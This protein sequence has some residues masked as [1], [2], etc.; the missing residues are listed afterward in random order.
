MD[1]AIELKKFKCINCSY[2]TNRK[3]NYMYHIN[4]KNPCKS[5]VKKPSGN[6]D[7][8]NKID[9][10]EFE[11][12]NESVYGDDC[13]F[14]DDSLCDNDEEEYIIQY[15]NN[16][17][18]KNK[19]CD[20]CDKT[21]SSLQS[22][23][24]HMKICNGVNSLQCTI[25]KKIFSSRNGKHL[26]MKYVTCEP[27]QNVQQINHYTTNNNNHS[28]STTT[29]NNI[30]NNNQKT[31]N[32]HNH[33]QI[34]AFGSENY[35]Y[36]IDENNR[37]RKIIQNKNA[38]MQKMIE[39]IHFDEDHPENHNILMTNLQSKHILIHDGTKFVKALKDQ[40]LDKMIK[41]KRKFLISNIEDLELSVGCEKEIK[42][43]LHKLRHDEESHKTLK[44][45]VELLCYNNKDLYI[46]NQIPQV[47]D[48]HI[49]G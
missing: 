43:K 45:K 20:K 34:N 26:H 44:E 49:N 13:E 4:R 37:L 6:N 2:S 27:V 48:K 3:S 46:E 22:L 1:E 30:T 12:V 39:A 10:N 7:K 47:L 35:D 9:V 41:D 24:R 15:C 17:K 40:T 42:D 18:Y 19:T 14:E 28:S 16:I 36:M 8:I 38:F 33:I 32:I 11:D 21:L 23:K 5:M 29:H 31:V 25:C